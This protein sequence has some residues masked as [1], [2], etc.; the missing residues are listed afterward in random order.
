MTHTDVRRPFNSIQA[1]R[2]P[3][4]VHIL[5]NGEQVNLTRKSA[6]KLLRYLLERKS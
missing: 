1:W 5:I 2:Y 6:D 3:E 4:S